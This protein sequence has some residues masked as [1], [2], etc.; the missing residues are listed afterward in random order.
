[1]FTPIVIWIGE[2]KNDVLSA[3]QKRYPTHVA[4]SG[5]VGLELAQEHRAQLVILDALS[6]QTSG[7]RICKQLR[8]SLPREISILHLH[9]TPN[10]KSEADHLLYP[11]I[12]SRRL[13]I[14]VDR[15]LKKT[16]KTLIRCGD[17]ALDVQERILHTKGQ[18]ISLNP[19]QSHLLEIFFK[20]PDQVLERS[21]LMQ[22]VW[23]T[24]YTGDT[25]TLDVHIRLVRRVLDGEPVP[26]V[27]KYLTTVRGVGYRLDIKPNKK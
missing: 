6:L 14:N 24:D 18:E 19:K 13:L 27:S 7:E 5:K 20:H 1:M 22:E 3:V 17:F 23:H 10:G 9:P 16:A 21:W 15:L 12:T 4:R 8:R 11:P 26:K 2:T 25:R